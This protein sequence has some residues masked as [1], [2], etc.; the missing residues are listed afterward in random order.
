MTIEQIS[1]F[2]ENKPGSFCNVAAVLS[3][4]GIN[5]RAMS[6]AES[7]SSRCAAR[8]DSR[9]RP[10]PP[11]VAVADAPRQ[12]LCCQLSGGS[13]AS[14]VTTSSKYRQVAWARSVREASISP[15]R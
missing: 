14:G 5:M 10:I 7:I 13:G 15:V 11:G 3:E 9:Y 1:V 6:V 2:L 12:G 8:Q 4:N